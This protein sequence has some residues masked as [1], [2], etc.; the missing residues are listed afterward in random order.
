M[1]DIV[2]KGRVLYAALAGGDAETLRRLLDADFQGQLA[3]GLPNGL[4]RLYRGREAMM[5]DGW[6]AVGALFDVTPRPEEIVDGGDLLIG[7]G[8]YVG[9]AKTTGKPLDAAFAHFWRFDGERFTAVQQI[10]D[11]PRWHEALRRD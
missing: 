1:A 5:R 2:T 9:V 8:R 10:T 7:R 4:G 11:S 3:E 6:E